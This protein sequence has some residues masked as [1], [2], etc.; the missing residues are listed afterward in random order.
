MR[1]AIVISTPGQV[2]FYKNIISELEARGHGTK[3]IARDYLETIP[4]LDELGLDYEVFAGKLES[5]IGKVARMPLHVL[6]GY[7]ALRDW[8][9]SVLLGFGIY[10]AYISRLLGV[11]C[12]TFTDSEHT[13]LQFLMYCPFVD[14]IITPECF[15]RDLGCRQMRVKSLK[16]LAYLHPRYFKPSAEV[17]E[18]LGLRPGQKYILMRFNGF[19]GMHDLGADGFSSDEKIRL[20]EELSQVTQVFISSESPL[21]DR[22][23]NHR[24][25][26]PMSDLHSVIYHADMVIADTGTVITEAAVLGTPAIRLDSYN[27]TRNLGNFSD[28][29]D[30][31]ELVMNVKSAS[32][33]LG[34]ATEILSNQDSKQEWRH[35]SL[36][37]ISEM[38][39]ITEMMVKMIDGHQFGPPFR[40]QQTHETAHGY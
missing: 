16:E 5:K 36:H 19:H 31:Y 39:D 20:V 40:R 29:E 32:D 9:P 12:L 37:M 3:I 13:P 11:P 14:V 26:L 30:T 2:H 38:T 24:L 25:R 34:K 6:D 8:K 15:S 4:V 10:S 27:G 7:R 21:P 33:V 28:L 18:K 22:I 1:I 23:D 35:R 17:L